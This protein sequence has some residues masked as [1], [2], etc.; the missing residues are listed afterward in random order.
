MCVGVS[1]RTTGGAAPAGPRHTAHGAGNT[2]VMV[3]PQTLN[4]ELILSL[5]PNASF[6]ISLLHHALMAVVSLGLLLNLC[7]TETSFYP[8]FP[9]IVILFSSPSPWLMT[10]PSHPCWGPRSHFL[11]CL[12]CHT[13]HISSVLI[14]EKFTVHCKRIGT[15]A[16]GSRD[17][18]CEGSA[19]VGESNLK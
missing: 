7:L 5:P 17:H 1:F 10:A 11:K 2:G 19:I 8:S 6:T 16:T 14:E 15:S 18:A 13:W 4:S 12:L 3:C 9:Y